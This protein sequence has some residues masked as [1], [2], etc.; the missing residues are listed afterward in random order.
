MVF[1]YGSAIINIIRLVIKIAEK[2]ILV[3][4]KPTLLLVI[5]LISNPLIVNEIGVTTP[6]STAIQPGINW[7]NCSY[8]PDVYFF[9]NE[10]IKELIKIQSI[11]IIW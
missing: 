11:P 5:C 1:Q 10:I 8:T 9:Y 4:S 2:E 3:I 7:L 6:A